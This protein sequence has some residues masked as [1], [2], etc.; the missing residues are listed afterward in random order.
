MRKLLTL[1]LAWCLLGFGN[2]MAETPLLD[3]RGVVIS[4]S[5]P[6]AGAVNASIA[7]SAIAIAFLMFMFASPALRQ[8]C[9]RR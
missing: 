8:I 7:A 9:I 6:L 2:A 4:A 1:L 3:D 5:A